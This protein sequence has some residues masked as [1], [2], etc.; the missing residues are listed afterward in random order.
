MKLSEFKQHL[1]SAD[2]LDFML[3]DGT[4]LPE[5]FH[6][7][8]IGFVTKRFMD[9]GGTVRKETAVSFQLWCANDYEHRLEAAKLLNIIALSERTLTMDDAEIEIEYQTDTIG[10]YGMHFDG[11]NF[12][13]IPKHTACLAQDQCGTGTQKRKVALS[14][15][16]SSAEKTCKP[17]TGCC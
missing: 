2:K 1:A 10:R 14:G 3:P 6:L 15:L 11:R 9:C 8:E 7:T 16:K 12:L 17:G 4:Y 5:H 13:L